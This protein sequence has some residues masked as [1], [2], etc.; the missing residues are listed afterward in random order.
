VAEYRA[1]VVAKSN[2]LVVAI[3]AVTTV[4]E[5]IALDLSF[6]VKE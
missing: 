3:N 6:P 4:E 2:E 5:L 1:D